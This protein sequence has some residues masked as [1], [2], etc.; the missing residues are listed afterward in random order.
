MQHSDVGKAPLPPRGNHLFFAIDFDLP[1]GRS[2]AS[3]GRYHNNFGAQSPGP[4]DERF[5]NPG[6][7]GGTSP[8]ITRVPFAG[9]YSGA[10]AKTPGASSSAARS[11]IHQAG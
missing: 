4:I 11:S 3:G 1:V 10:S 9:P 6:A 8:W 2:V 5:D 7:F